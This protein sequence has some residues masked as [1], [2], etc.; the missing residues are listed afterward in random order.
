VGGFDESIDLAMIDIL[1]RSACLVQ[2]TI[3]SAYSLDI[4][5]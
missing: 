2:D 3:E 1:T 5:I 4:V